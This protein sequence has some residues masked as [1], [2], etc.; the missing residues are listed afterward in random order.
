[1][2]RPILMV[3]VLVIGFLL[4]CSGGKGSGKKRHKP[5]KSKPVS[6]EVDAY[7][8]DCHHVF[9]AEHEVDQGGDD[10]CTALN[11]DQNCSP[12]PSG[13]WD[14]G[15]SCIEDCGDP[16]TSCQDECGDSCDSCK[17]TCDGNK[18]CETQC[19]QNRA[20]CRDSCLANKA[21]CAESTCV[22]QQKRCYD[23][24]E[25][26]VDKACPDCDAI[27]QCIIDAWNEEAD[28]RDACKKPGNRSECMEWCMP[29]M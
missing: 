7:L 28:W 10:E 4:A 26:K 14:K 13:C 16:C 25:G 2:R 23:K 22:D 8:A 18:K 24:F 11:Y 12:D 15:Q 17:S 3:F 6:T 21:K 27:R 1:M 20:E 9:P 5:D 29:G 19:A